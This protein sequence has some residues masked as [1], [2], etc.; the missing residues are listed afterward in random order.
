MIA[1]VQRLVHSYRDAG[2]IIDTNLLLL[3]L[4]GWRDPDSLAAFKRTVD[5]QPDDFHLADELVR[6]FAAT[7]RLISTPTVLAEVSNL[8]RSGLHGPRL[9]QAL[10]DFGR[11]ILQTEVRDVACSGLVVRDEYYRLGLTDTAI[12]EIARQGVLVLTD[13]VG[14]VVGLGNLGL[15]VINFGILRK[16]L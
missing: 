4:I 3:L 5:Y 8:L 13:D 16:L 12:I 1:E 11:V 6:P 2:L 14:L 15:D 10:T 7:G 9:H